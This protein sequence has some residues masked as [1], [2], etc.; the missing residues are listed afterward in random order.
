MGLLL[1]GNIMNAYYVAAILFLGLSVYLG[2]LGNNYES[3]KSNSQQL[4]EISKEFR[5]LGEQ[6][7]E[8]KGTQIEAEEIKEIDEKYKLLAQQYMKA[9]PAKAQS[10]I[11]EKEEDKLEK[12]NISK[13]LLPQIDL[14]KETA[15]NLS[16]VFSSEGADLQYT[17]MSIPTNLF[18]NEPFQLRLSSSMSEYWSIH[19]VDREPGIGMMFVRILQEKDGRELLTNDSIVFRWVKNERFAFSLNERIGEE[20]KR[21][22]FGDLNNQYHPIDDAKTQLETLVVNLFKY[23][24]AKSEL[25]KTEGK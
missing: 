13:T 25:K 17:E 8:L 23:V 21:N 11:V 7:T 12:I 10:L 18:S 6:I 16:T 3:K 4:N 9:L 5:T 1:K 14:V 15:K 2:Y 19:L 20:V 22:V 24:I